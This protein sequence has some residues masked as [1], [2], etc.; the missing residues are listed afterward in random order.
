LVKC[1]AKSRDTWKAKARASKG[2]SQQRKHRIRLLEAS[3][4]RWKEKATVLEAQLTGMQGQGR[5]RAAEWEAL[6]KSRWRR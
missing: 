3:K 4:G 2:T 5:A 6:R 1:F